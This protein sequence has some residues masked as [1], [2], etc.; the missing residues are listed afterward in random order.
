M[1][2]RAPAAASSR[3]AVLPAGPAPTTIA[4][5]ARMAPILPARAPRPPLCYHGAEMPLK[6]F[7]L[8]IIPVTAIAA[9]LG[10]II[11]DLV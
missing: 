4:S 9:S 5:N 7:L 2:V 8:N 3:A 1:S 6:Y 10:W 11:G